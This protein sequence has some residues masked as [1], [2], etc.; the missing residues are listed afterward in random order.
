[1]VSIKA[2][3]GCTQGVSSPLEEYVSPFILGSIGLV[4]PSPVS[5]E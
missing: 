3:L 1:M 2:L 4:P 5:K